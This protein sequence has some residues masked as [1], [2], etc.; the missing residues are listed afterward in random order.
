MLAEL[1]RKASELSILLTDDDEI[2]ALNRTYRGEDAATDVLAFAMREGDRLAGAERADLLGDVVISIDTARRQ[3]KRARRSIDAELR[4]L[5]AH[6]LLHLVGIDHP[7]PARLS[8]MRAMARVLCR[9]AVFRER[10]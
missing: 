6:G 3:A 9:A 2:R 10:I 8:R 1:G 5:L 4:S 7:T